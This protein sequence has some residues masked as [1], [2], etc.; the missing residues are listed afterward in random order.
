MCA[1]L[2]TRDTTINNTRLFSLGSHILVGEGNKFI[3]LIK[4]K[5]FKVIGA[6]KKM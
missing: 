6:M 2:G 1:V 3:K 5:I 4:K